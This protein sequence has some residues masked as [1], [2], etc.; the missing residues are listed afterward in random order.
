MYGKHDDPKQNA[1][2][3][4]DKLAYAILHAKFPDI[5]RMGEVEVTEDGAKFIVTELEH[6]DTR[7]PSPFYSRTPPG[8]W[9]FTITVTAERMP[10]EG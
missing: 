2:S 1:K 8:E 10:D 4:A 5:R 6:T 3:M 9:K 7:P